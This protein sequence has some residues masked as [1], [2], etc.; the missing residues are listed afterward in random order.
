[1]QPYPASWPLEPSDQNKTF[2]IKRWL[3]SILKIEHEVKNK[4]Y[5]KIFSEIINLLQ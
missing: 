3:K 1:M 2:R 4:K 5:Y